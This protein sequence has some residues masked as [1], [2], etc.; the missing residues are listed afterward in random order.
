[1]KFK[2]LKLGAKLSIGFGS[3]IFISAVIGIM[4]IVNMTNVSTESN[5]LSTE[6]V[7]EV[8]LVSQLRVEVNHL[9]L[10]MRGYGFTED[11]KFYNSA[12]S[13]IEKIKKSIEEIEQFEVTVTQLPALEDQIKRIK[14][15]FYKYYEQILLTKKLNDEILA[16][17]ESMV[18]DANTYMKN[19]Q[20]YLDSQKKQV[21]EEMAAGR[22]NLSRIEK[23]EKI[24]EIMI[25]GN[26]TIIALYKSEARRDP[27]IVKDAYV[28]FQGIHNNLKDIVEETKLERNLLN[29]SNIDK[30]LSSYESAMNGF[31]EAWKR[32]EALNGE[33]LISSS[34]LLDVCAEASETGIKDTQNVA[35]GSMVILGTS[36]IVLIIGLIL[37]MIIG[38]GLSFFLTGMITLPIQKGVNFAKTIAKGD[39]TATIDVDQKDEVGFLADALKDMVYQV[40]LVINNVK[41]AATQIA[42]AS[43]QLTQNAQEQASSTEEASSSMEEMASNIQQNTDNAQQTESIARKAA[44]EIKDGYESVTQT[45]ESMKAIAEKIKIIGE[46]AEKTDLLAINAAIEAARAGEHGKGFAVVAT[47]VRKLAERSQVAAKE[48]NDLSRDSVLIAEKTGNQMASIVPEIEKTS[49]LVQ[50]IAAASREQSAGTD[51]VNSA[52]QQLNQANQENAASSEELSSQAIQMRE[53]VAFFHTGSDDNAALLHAKTSQKKIHKNL[54]TPGVN[55]NLKSDNSSDNEYTSF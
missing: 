41:S 6:F 37:A 19:C 52:I 4:A 8:R 55:L 46:I 43:E 7:P 40:K 10:E 21:R 49:K 44:I 36:K 39:L 9:M 28:N 38:I 26:Y 20:E 12:L 24:N 30:A 42:A 23:I 18:S 3:L 50:E 47:E 31:I 32:R 53:Q 34:A 16:L 51:Q 11:E 14:E 13:D 1:M 25:T 45:V 2:D 15:A 54:S 27:K 29:L 17:R 48:I 22:T 33:R 5:Y 35:D